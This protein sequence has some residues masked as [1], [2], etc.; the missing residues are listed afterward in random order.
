MNHWAHM[1]H[2]HRRNSYIRN[3]NDAAGLVDNVKHALAPTDTIEA[4]S[5]VPTYIGVGLLAG[6]VL[7]KV[8]LKKHAILVSLAGGAGGY[9]YGK[10]LALAAS[11]SN[12]PPKAST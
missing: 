9:F 2:H 1:L 4:T 11:G 8:A 6:L 12:P 5:T 10:K 7:G 3:P